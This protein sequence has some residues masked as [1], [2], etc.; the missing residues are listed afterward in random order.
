ML[1][2]G[3]SV[4]SIILF[5]LVQRVL[6]PCR[7]KC[8]YVCGKYMEDT[9][10]KIWQLIWLDF[11]M[12][13]GPKKRHLWLFTQQNPVNINYLIIHSIVFC[14]MYCSASTLHVLRFKSY[15]CH[16]VV[17]AVLGFLL[18]LKLMPCTKHLD[19]S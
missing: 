2:I 16:P 5:C 18:F 17:F 3:M 4:V 19:L 7:M 10:A 13:C 11:I 1:W 9:L 8:L 6:L 12:K 15:A 14:C